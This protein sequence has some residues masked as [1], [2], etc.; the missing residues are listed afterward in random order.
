MNRGGIFSEPT[1]LGIPEQG[2]FSNQA[3]SD[4]G[5]FSNQA[6]SCGCGGYA[7]G[8]DDSKMALWAWGALAVLVLV[9]LA[10]HTFAGKAVL[11]K[12]TRAGFSFGDDEGSTRFYT[13]KTIP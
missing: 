12:K 9:P 8:E 4:S 7:L 13:E 2:V 3:L 1:A 11:E 6:L 5:V 10:W